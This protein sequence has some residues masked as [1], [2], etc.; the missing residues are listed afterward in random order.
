MAGNCVADGRSVVSKVSA[1][2]GA[3][4][5][6][7]EDLSGVTGSDVRLGLLDRC[8]VA[9]IEKVPGCRPSSPFT[10]AATLPAHATALGKA[11]LAFSTPDVVDKVI[12]QGLT[13]YTAATITTACR[14]VHALTTTRRRGLAFERGELA[15]GYLAAA[16]PIFGPRGEIVGA[17]APGPPS[18]ALSAV[19]HHRRETRQGPSS[20]SLM[21]HIDRR[22]AQPTR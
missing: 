22:T 14:L 8:R 13:R 6:V 3:F 15:K 4:A 16:T 1:V 2:M 7:I 21:D 11:L 17:L 12:G 20:A 9:Y 10:A 18:A 5:P 19:E